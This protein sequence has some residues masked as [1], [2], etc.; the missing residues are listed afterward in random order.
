M[1]GGSNCHWL[2]D[3]VAESI[4][5]F[6]PF[7]S[8]VSSFAVLTSLLKA[9][10]GLEISE[11]PSEGLVRSVCEAHG[12]EMC[13]ELGHARIIGRVWVPKNSPGNACRGSEELGI[14]EE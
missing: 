11:G 1:G 3:P 8:S 12:F 5:A 6:G 2:S 10:L 14:L 4:A 13:A 7:W 9:G